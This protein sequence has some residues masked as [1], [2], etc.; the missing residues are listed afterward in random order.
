M[1]HPP[2]ALTTTPRRVTPLFFSFFFSDALLY[3]Y[4]RPP[5]SLSFACVTT[6]KPLQKTK[7]YSLYEN[8][9]NDPTF[10]LLHARTRETSV[11][12]ALTTLNKR[13]RGR[14]HNRRLLLAGEP[15]KTSA[16]IPSIKDTHGRDSFNEYRDPPLN[17]FLLH[18]RCGPDWSEMAL[19]R[20]V[21][22]TRPIPRSSVGT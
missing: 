17:P 2:A 21:S 19:S 3:G 7:M 4:H 10:A 5:V 20:N 6:P 13:L 9:V 12:P 1:V 18:V 16:C 22:D 11:P 15:R 14:T 8:V